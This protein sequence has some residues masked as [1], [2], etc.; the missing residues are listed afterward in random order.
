M[1]KEIES[2]SEKV[3]QEEVDLAADTLTGDIRDALLD[4]IKNMQK[5]WQQL[6]ENQ[7]KGVAIAVEDMAKNVVRKAVTIIA[8]QG[9][10]VI[11]AS[12]EKI[13]IKDGIKAEVALSQFSEHRHA[14]CDSQGKAV[15]IV[16]ADAEEFTG[17]RE[18]V[19]IDKDQ[20]DLEDTVDDTELDEDKPIFDNT[21]FAETNS[22]RPKRQYTQ[23]LRDQLA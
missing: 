17:E 18:A 15:L 4:N 11:Q 14:L 7:Q 21:D 23:R 2:V 20:G 13:T 9:R 22:E 5:P 16:V 1:T 10:T 3:S 8:K 19:E 12:L 6:T